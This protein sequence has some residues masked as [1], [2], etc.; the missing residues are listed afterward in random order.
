MGKRDFLK[1]A[2][3]LWYRS[4][5]PVAPESMKEINRLLALDKE[6]RG[7]VSANAAALGDAEA[8][9]K[10]AGI[11]T[12]RELNVILKEELARAADDLEVANQPL[13]NGLRQQIL[14]MRNDAENLARN[15]Q[16]P[17]QPSAAQVAEW[18]R[19]KDMGGVLTTRQERLLEAAGYRETV[20]K[21]LA[22]N[23]TL[24]R[25]YQ[26]LLKD[27]VEHAERLERANA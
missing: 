25:G 3:D 20:T 9:R 14:G 17:P 27:L 8:L 2:D 21:S 19:T 16:A 22:E 13:S 10:R 11:F 23:K 4:A 18:R 12:N 6:S 26:Q 15:N 7:G 1:E 24:S 5:K